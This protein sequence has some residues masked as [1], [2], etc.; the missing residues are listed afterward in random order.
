[1]KVSKFSDSQ[2]LSILKQNEVGVKLAKK[3]ERR[4]LLVLVMQTFKLNRGK[5]VVRHVSADTV[6]VDFDVFKDVIF[7][8]SP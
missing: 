3:V 5:P 7:H 1:M 6:V 4:C 8:V 2:I